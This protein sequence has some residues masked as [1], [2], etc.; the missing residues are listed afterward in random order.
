MEPQIV[1]K[2]DQYWLNLSEPGREQYL[3][4]EDE[5]FEVPY[6]ASKFAVQAEPTRI[7]DARDRLLGEFVSEKGVY[8]RD[9]ADLPEYLKKALIASED[10]EFYRHHGVNWRSTARA[11]LVNLRR[12]HLRQGGST[13][14][15][16]LAK[17]MFT[18]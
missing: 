2:M 18:T 13:L 4:G 11:M 14:T 9:P 15:Q 5:V 16:Q 7:F 10:A 12:F 17:V 1:G 3:L 8:V 6:M